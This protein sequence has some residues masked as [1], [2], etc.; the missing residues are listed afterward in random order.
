MSIVFDLRLATISARRQRRRRSRSRSTIDGVDGHGAGRHVGHARRGARRHRD[1][2]ALRDRHA[3][4]RSAPAAC[5][6]SRSK[7]RRA[8]PASC[9]TPVARGHEGHDAEPEARAAAPR[10]DGAVHL[11]SSAR[12]PR[13]ARPTATAS[14]RTWPAPSASR[15][16]RYGYDGENHLRRAAKDEQQPLLHVRSESSASSARAACAPARRCRAPSR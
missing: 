3:R 2:E 9:T 11:R 13:P 6:S 4:R 5:A 15:E 8:I 1:P 7:A 12:L 10:R 14:C 16:V